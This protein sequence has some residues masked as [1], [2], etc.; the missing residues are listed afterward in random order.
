MKAGR[1]GG[2]SGGSNGVPSIWK[3]TGNS[4]ATQVPWTPDHCDGLLLSS[5]Y[6]QTA[7]GVEEL[8][9]PVQD[10]GEGGR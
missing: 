10:I 8:V 1:G 6:R 9:T 4:E 3:S 5:S 2:T 7:E